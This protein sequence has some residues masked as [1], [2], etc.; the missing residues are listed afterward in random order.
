M[1]SLKTDGEEGTD[2]RVEG[3]KV[4]TLLAVVIADQLMLKLFARDLTLTSVTDSHEDKPK[5]LH[6]PGYAFDIRTWGMNGED[7]HKFVSELKN[8]LGDE[9]DVV[10][11]GSHIHVEFDPPPTFKQATPQEE[12]SLRVSL[13]QEEKEALL[14]ETYEEEEE[15]SLLSSVRLTN[16]EKKLDKILDW[17]KFNGEEMKCKASGEECN[18]GFMEAGDD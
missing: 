16:I 12:K 17:I 4:E 13:T 5:S 9:Y 8:L 2:A 15:P 18:F 3:M 14:K 11:E 1:I 7:K 6:N 10:E